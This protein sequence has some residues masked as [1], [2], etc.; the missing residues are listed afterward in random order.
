MEEKKFIYK[1]IINLIRGLGNNGFWKY[2][3]KLQ[4]KHTTERFIQNRCILIII[5]LVKY[6][7]SSLLK[8]D[9][10]IVNI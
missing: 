8:N 4:F 2:H 7:F 5:V 1:L 6:L 3:N 10:S 9:V